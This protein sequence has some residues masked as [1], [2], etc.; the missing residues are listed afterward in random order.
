MPQGKIRLATGPHPVAVMLYWILLLPIVLVWLICMAMLRSIWSPND[1]IAGVFAV[2][3]I[4]ICG[5]IVGFGALLFRRMFWLDGTML[6]QRRLF[7]RRRCDLSIAQVRAEWVSPSPTGVTAELP[8]LV[9]GGPGRR[10]I[11]LWLRDP[12]RRRS[13]L[14]EEQLHALADA[15]ICGREHD[16]RAY[17]VAD[18]LRHMAT[19]PFGN[20]RW[21][22]W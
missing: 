14:P 20:Q 8:R 13:Q 12:D 9:A 1:L 18:A 6:I 22:V 10:R 7:G 21:Q 5:I 16:D 4:A 19:D 11:K 2:L 17:L 3:T 15:I